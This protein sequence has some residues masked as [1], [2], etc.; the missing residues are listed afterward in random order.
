MKSL[1]GES[2]NERKSDEI[3]SNLLRE[4]KK[5]N[6]GNGNKRHDYFSNKLIR[7]FSL[8]N[9]LHEWKYVNFMHINLHDDFLFSSCVLI[10]GSG[11]ER[12][13]TE[14]KCVW[15]C[16]NWG[17]LDN[18]NN[19]LPLIYTPYEFGP[20]MPPPPLSAWPCPI[21]V[22]V[23]IPYIFFS[24]AASDFLFWPNK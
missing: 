4:W 17:A 7:M 2:E 5:E 21:F 15:V 16:V 3:R 18:W 13:P 20:N 11:Q 12:K 19:D 14:K 23:F 1:Q 22:T 10:P 8:F 6:N 24:A 9:W